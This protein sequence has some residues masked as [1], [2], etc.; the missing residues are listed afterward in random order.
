MLSNLKYK[1]IY[2]CSLLRSAGLSARI[3][4]LENELRNLQRTHAHT[5]TGGGSPQLSIRPPMASKRLPMTSQRPLS[6]QA[7]MHR[8]MGGPGQRNN[9]DVRE[10]KSLD[11]HGGGDVLVMRGAGGWKRASDVPPAEHDV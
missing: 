8:T 3:A 5:P 9:L 11:P 6:Y 1:K 7:T 2:I 10:C 4:A